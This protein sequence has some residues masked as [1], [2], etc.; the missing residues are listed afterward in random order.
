V[1]LL[2]GSGASAEVRLGRP[3]V[4]RVIA[5]AQIDP[6]VGFGEAVGEVRVYDGTRLVARRP[7][8][9]SE[10]VAVPG[11]TKKAGWYA[12]EAL[13]EARDMLSSLS[14]F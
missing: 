1:P 11:L 7:L 9:A 12:G 10:T 8:I 14:P 2:A 13:H 6:P 3:L 5:P 4:E